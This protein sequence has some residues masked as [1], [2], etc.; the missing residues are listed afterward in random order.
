MHPFLI[1]T[2]PIIKRLIQATLSFTLGCII[3]ESLLALPV[4]ELFSLNKSAITQHL[5]WQPLT[6]LFL[7][8]SPTLSFGFLLNLAFSMLLLWML[9]SQVFEFLGK[10]R[11]LLIYFGSAFV[12]ALC[13]LFAMQCTNQNALLS[14][15]PPVLLAI[16]TIWTMCMPSQNMLVFFFIPLSAKW[17]LAIALFGTIVSSGIQREYVQ[18]AMY[19]GT[20]LFAYLLGIMK[21]NLRG[22][23]I[24]LFRLEATLKRISHTLSIF[25]QWKV[26]SFFRT[27]RSNTKERD[28]LFVDHVLAKIS[29][30]GKRSLTFLEL[31]R[32]KWISFKKRLRT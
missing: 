9:G 14:T 23:F 12:S 21:W 13:A 30:N 16:A 32:L 29:Q 8:P 10:R 19:S 26:M 15:C 25:W 31:L 6:S 4:Q 17:F 2:S 27:H 20:F 11:F 28:E 22:P 5:Y 18:F 3:F 7:I 1:S 24:S